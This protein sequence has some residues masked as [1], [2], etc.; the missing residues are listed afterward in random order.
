MKRQIRLGVFETNSSMTH[1]LSM[2]T[3]EEFEKWK[4]GEVWWNRWDDGFTPIEE[5]ID[6]EE[7]WN[8][9]CMTYPEFEDL[10]YE[11]VFEKE[12]TTPSGETVIA[13]GYAGYD[14]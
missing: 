7:K 14:Y 4:N 10:E 1:A 5:D 8:R 13:F 12:Y 9:G 2:C 6:E 11:G 3:K